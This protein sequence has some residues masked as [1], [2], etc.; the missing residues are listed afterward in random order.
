MHRPPDSSRRLE[1]ASTDRVLDD[2]LGCAPQRRRAFGDTA[3]QRALPRLV[4]LMV[5]PG[6]AAG[7]VVQQDG[8]QTVDRLGEPSIRRRRGLELLP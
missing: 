6:A 4:H 8:L 3:G 5:G 1:P 7:R 2:L